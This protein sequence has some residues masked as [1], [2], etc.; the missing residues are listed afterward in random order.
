MSELSFAG[1]VGIVTGAA[2]GI[3]K[4]IA[5]FLAAK[6]LPL[7]I[8]DLD[9]DRL[10]GLARTLRS[11]GGIVSSFAGDVSKPSGASAII[12]QTIGE[13]GRIDILINNAG[14][15]NTSSFS[16]MPD[17]QFNDLL[18]VN[19][20]SAFH[21]TKA[22]WPHMVGR[23]YGR[24]LFFSSQAVFGSAH[25]SHYSTSKAALVGLTRSLAIEGSRLGINVNGL[26]PFAV[27]D[28]ASGASDSIRRR[29]TDAGNRSGSDET[30]PEAL[31]HP[32]NVAPAAGWLCHEDC[33]IT[34]EVILSGGGRI[35]KLILAETIGYHDP[36]PTMEAV[37]DNWSRITD[38]AGYR[39]P[40]NGIE[41]SFFALDMP[42]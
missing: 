15:L 34:G 26:I 10:E 23:G 39:N 31:M 8:N 40:R 21:M 17:A 38:E 16:D 32:R 36:R 5:T 33:G 2:R 35:A 24:I 18:D 11:A 6:G 28:M 12:E 22:A 27:T 4:A 42:R 13:F 20:G 41:S 14:I 19:I 29:F 7:A 1:K 37:R 3:G 9:D 25:A 30:D